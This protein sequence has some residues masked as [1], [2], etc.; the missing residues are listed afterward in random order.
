M[1]RRELKTL[2]VNDEDLDCE[3]KKSVTLTDLNLSHLGIN[4]DDMKNFDLIVYKGKK[5]TK[6]L[7]SNCFLSGKIG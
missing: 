6:I 7:R 1:E 4:I 3:F 2:L 5:G